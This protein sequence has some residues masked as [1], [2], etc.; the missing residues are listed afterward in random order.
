MD[1]FR[2]TAMWSGFTG[3]PGYSAFHFAG[4]GGLISDATQCVERVEAAFDEIKAWLP[5]TVSIQVDSEVEV[6]DSDT[7]ELTGAEDVGTRTAIQGGTAGPYSAATGA[8]INWR[9]GDYRFGR[10]IRGRTFIVPIAGDA[11]EA[12]GT[13][14]VNPRGRFQ[15]FGNIMTSSDFDSEFGVWSRPRNGSGG[16]FASATGYSVPDMAAVL[17]SRRD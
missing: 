5:S 17:R 4:G 6:L 2:I 7:G 15:A 11:Y 13:L 1:I 14:G 12:D 3:A 8:V 16:V 10:R 9:T